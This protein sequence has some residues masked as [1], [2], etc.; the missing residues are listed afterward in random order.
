MDK[1][2]K[3]VI[4]DDEP[5]SVKLIQINIEKYFPQVVILAT[6]SDPESAIVPFAELAPDLLLL[7]IEMPVM[8]GF[9]FLEK[10]APV[11]CS[12]AFVTAYNEFAVKAFKFNALDYLLKPVHKE[13]LQ[14][15]FE[16]VG[17]QK[18]LEAEQLHVLQQQFKKGMIS[19]IAIPGQTGVSFVDLKDIV[20]IE[21]SN[22]Y[23]NLVLTD[24][25]RLLISKT[26]KDIQQVLEEHQFLRI[27]RQ[28]IINLNEVKH[29]NRNEGLL[30]MTTG[31]VLPVSRLQKEK[32]VAQYGW[33]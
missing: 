19:K 16:K 14:A 1:K 20:F 31:D 29:F 8:N 18:H 10:I 11:D 23:S 32:L 21:A 33:L 5:D 13:D 30:T 6:F 2:I 15:V 24:K 4:I 22:N 28:Y 27:H 26:L 3:V 17:K 12:V 9:D 25:K 7:D